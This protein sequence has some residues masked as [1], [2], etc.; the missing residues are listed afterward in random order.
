[1]GSG[2]GNGR[3]SNC[4]KSARPHRLLHERALLS[5]GRFITIPTNFLMMAMAIFMMI[6]LISRWRDQFSPPAKPSGP[7]PS[8]ALLGEIRDLLKSSGG[9]MPPIGV[10]ERQHGD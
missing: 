6:R 1:M 7:T 10:L 9:A 4:P 2:I 5:Y 8:E 3:S